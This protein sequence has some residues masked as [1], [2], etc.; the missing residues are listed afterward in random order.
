MTL[1]MHLNAD[2]YKNYIGLSWVHYMIVLCIEI[3][4]DLICDGLNWDGARSSM[5]TAQLEETL[6]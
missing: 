3:R 4:K 6:S 2:W 5:G 1:S